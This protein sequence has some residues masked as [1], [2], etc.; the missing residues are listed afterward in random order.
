M[1]PRARAHNDY[2]SCPRCNLPNLL[3]SVERTPT[4]V[5]CECTSCHTRVDVFVPLQQEGPYGADGIMNDQVGGELE[6]AVWWD[7]V[8]PL[9]QTHNNRTPPPYQL[10]QP[11]TFERI[12]PCQGCHRNIR[13]KG[14]N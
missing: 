12:V 5:R 7:F 11:K 3:E 6:D 13:V 1:P 8:C 10:G 2:W 9:C 4:D 14:T